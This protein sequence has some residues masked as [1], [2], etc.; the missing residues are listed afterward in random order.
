MILD[1]QKE[2]VH[3]ARH[4]LVLAFI[5]LQSEVPTVAEINTD[6]L[7]VVIKQGT[8]KLE[9]T[10]DGFIVHCAHILETDEQC[11]TLIEK[12]PAIMQRTL[13]KLKDR[14]RA[15]LEHGLRGEERDVLF[16]SE[17]IIREACGVPHRISLEFS[18]KAAEFSKAMER[19][20]FRKLSGYF[21]LLNKKLLAEKGY[22]HSVDITH[23]SAMSAYDY[24]QMAT[25]SFADG[26][27]FS[28]G[29]RLLADA[30]NMLNG[31]TMPVGEYKLH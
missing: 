8:A 18:G 5:T 2:I 3:R 24:Y 30:H 17:D 20:P 11:E 1:R 7:G 10:Q 21:S 4:R 16:E 27:S 29:N 22:V 28:E 26:F 31:M 14:N 12:N 23:K 9:A 25:K 19:L 6:N 13:N 15:M